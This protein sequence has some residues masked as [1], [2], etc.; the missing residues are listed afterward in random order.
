[1]PTA[2]I[3]GYMG[4]KSTQETDLHG[5]WKRAGV[6]SPTLHTMHHSQGQ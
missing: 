4:L 6:P 2:D 3:Q 5:V 1:M